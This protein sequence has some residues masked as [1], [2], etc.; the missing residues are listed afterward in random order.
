MEPVMD[1]S[2]RGMEVAA[3]LKQ[4]RGKQCTCLGICRPE[5]HRLAG[6]GHIA[7]NELPSLLGQHEPK[8]HW[9]ALECG[10]GCI[11]TPFDYYYIPRDRAKA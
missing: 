1:L 6:D 7:A 4:F 10:V 11:V 9:M 8:T 2:L 5:S 3:R